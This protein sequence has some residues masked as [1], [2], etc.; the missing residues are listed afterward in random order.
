MECMQKVFWGELF[1][2]VVR[3]NGV[4]PY[5]TQIQAGVLANAQ[6]QYSTVYG[7]VPSMVP[8]DTHTQERGKQS[9]KATSIISKTKS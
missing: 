2:R 7:M 6:H 1:V 9:D 3:H 4:V 8:Y 5:P